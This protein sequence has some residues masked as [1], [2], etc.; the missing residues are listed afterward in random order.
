VNRT[1]GAQRWGHLLTVTLTP[2][3]MP[4]PNLHR[5]SPLILPGEAPT[6][7]EK[8]VDDGVTRSGGDPGALESRPRCPPFSFACLRPRSFLAKLPP[9]ERKEMRAVSKASPKVRG[10]RVVRLGGKDDSLIISEASRMDQ[11]YGAKQ[12]GHVL[13][14]TPGHWKSFR[15]VFAPLHP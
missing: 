11:T 4:S 8:G 7:G 5:S 13:T 12:G 15:D 2:P 3:A 1:Y 10:Y 14:V 6:A 9:W